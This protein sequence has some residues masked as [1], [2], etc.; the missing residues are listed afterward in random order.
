MN[1]RDAWIGDGVFI[2][3]KSVADLHG[4]NSA[5]VRLRG[6]ADEER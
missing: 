4:F 1:R 5:G 6:W 2:V 3:C